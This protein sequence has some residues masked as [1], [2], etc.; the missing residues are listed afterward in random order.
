MKIIRHYLELVRFSH[1]LFALPFALAA[2]FAALKQRDTGMD[3]VLLG[4]VLVCMVS[5]RTA[6][7]AFNR[8]VDRE[9]D[10]HNPRTA[11]RHL[12]RG[13]VTVAEV[14]VLVALCCGFYQK[15]TL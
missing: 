12:P 4:W 3:W 2:F 11:N 15:L 5:A 9:I 14:G 6:A 10:R 8:L 13:L 1:T 7:M